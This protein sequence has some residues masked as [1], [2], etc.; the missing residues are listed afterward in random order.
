[1]SAVERCNAM[2]QP[3]ARSG[4]S[5]LHMLHI[6]KREKACAATSH[7][8]WRKYGASI[9]DR[10]KQNIGQKNKDKNQCSLPNPS[11]NETISNCQVQQ[12]TGNL[13]ARGKP[14]RT[15]DGSAQNDLQS[16]LKITSS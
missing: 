10:K 7:K 8:F 1:M 16:L 3:D 5:P 15:A 11:P 4:L 9:I 13:L 12:E 14:L 2:F 6:G